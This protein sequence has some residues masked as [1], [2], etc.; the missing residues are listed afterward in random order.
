[1]DL[2]YYI[3][4]STSSNTFT[5]QMDKQLGPDCPHLW[6]CIIDLLFYG[7]PAGDILIFLVLLTAERLILVVNVA[8]V[9]YIPQETGDSYCVLLKEKPIA[10]YAPQHYNPMCLCIYY[11]LSSITSVFRKAMRISKC[12]GKV[13]YDYESTHLH[14]SDIRGQHSY[15]HRLI[16]ARW[17]TQ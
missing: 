16:G 12:K 1:M 11:L 2:A 8:N 6:K 7:T 17:V 15:F 10:L 5:S 3:V 9:D 14:V 4:L 13:N